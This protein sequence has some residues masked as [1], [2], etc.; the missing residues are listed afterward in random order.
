[1]TE[2]LIICMS[3]I[4]L[5]AILIILRLRPVFDFENEKEIFFLDNPNHQKETFLVNIFTG[6]PKSQ[7]CQNSAENG[8][9]YKINSSL[10][11]QYIEIQNS[12]YSPIKCDSIFF[13]DKKYPRI[14][15]ISSLYLRPLFNSNT[16]IPECLEQFLTKYNLGIEAGEWGAILI[17]EKKPILAS[18]FKNIVA[19]FGRIKF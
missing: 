13:T 7:M 17:R 9:I 3:L 16:E 1:M 15:W 8:L 4:I 10:S 6:Y 14:C 11:W 19:E 2:N 5:G 18:E 12:S